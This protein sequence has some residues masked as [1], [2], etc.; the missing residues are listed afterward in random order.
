MTQTIPDNVR[1]AIEV[2]ANEFRRYPTNRQIPQSDITKMMES[3]KD[4]GVVQPITA[5][6]KRDPETK[7]AYL[8]IVIGETRW[9]GCKAISETY[10]VPVFVKELDD[11]QAAKI[12]TIENF[13]RKDL[14]EIE[15]AQ[16]IQNL[17]DTGWEIDEI[18]KFLGREKT[19][20]YARLALMKLSAEAQT[21]VREKNITINVAA[22][23]ASLPEEQRVAALEA[24]VSPTHAA[25]SLPEKQALELLDRDFIEPAKIS[26]E[27]DKRRDVILEHNPGAKWL[28]HEMAK[29]MGS[30]NSGYV[31]ADKSPE[32]DLL[33]DAARAGE[34]VVPTWGELA[35]KHGAELVIG[36]N[37]SNEAFTYVLPTPLIDAEKAA[38][39]AKPA[40]CIFVHEAAIHEAREAS[41]KRKRE[42]EAHRLTL[43]SESE[44]LGN[45]ILNPE[46][47]KA[48]ACKK[49]VEMGFYDCL[50]TYLETDDLAR[51]LGIDPL[52][53]ECEKKTDA[54]VMKYLRSKAF[55]PFEAM[56]RLQLAQHV[57]F[58]YDVLAII[59][60]GMGV[61]RADFPAHYQEYEA[62]LA[63]RAA[64][65]TAEKEREAEAKAAKEKEDAA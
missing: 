31:R 62:M 50:S 45:L 60:E 52:D 1:A 32:R 49:L 8:E 40:E 30:W 18:C 7:E 6:E 28:T 24:L 13:Q 65:A 14:D 25:K 38:F 56:A 37:Y 5:R 61:K 46:G 58:G 21:A 29:A 59:F 12:H 33:S 10:P 39:S 55:S 63:A 11:K 34:L 48:T 51:L 44:T 26:K 20:I 54:A 57:R 22:K 41:E 43:Y 9:L 36:C 35:K 53:E 42:Q 16:A 3:V 27:W 19:G 23:L 4:V 2:P 64:E 15:E 47:L 17:K